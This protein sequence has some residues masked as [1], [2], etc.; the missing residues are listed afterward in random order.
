[1]QN[2][3]GVFVTNPDGCAPFYRFVSIRLESNCLEVWEAL[4]TLESQEYEGET[5]VENVI[6][7]YAVQVP[8]TTQSDGETVTKFRTEHRTRTVP[9]KKRRAGPTDNEASL[10][11]RSYTVSVPYSEMIDGVAV[12]RSRLETRTRMVAENEV[13]LELVPMY[14]SKSYEQQNISLYDVSGKLVDF[15]LLENAGGLVPAIQ[16]AGPSHIVPFFS[17]I[18]KPSS[19]FL[20]IT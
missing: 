3:P 5:Y 7:T 20:V 10:I 11:E 8:Y 18:L 15:D 9:V 14:Q 1:M 17:E 6:Q 13:P 2:P 12:T 16:I 19:L 4:P